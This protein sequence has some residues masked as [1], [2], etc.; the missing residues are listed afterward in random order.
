MQ[1]F[2]IIKGTLEFLMQL[3]VS[4]LRQNHGFVTILAVQSSGLG[5]DVLHVATAFTATRERSSALGQAAKADFKQLIH[6]LDVLDKIL[7]LK[8]ENFQGVL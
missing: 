3:D 4:G 1:Q 6:A 8:L 5:N 2:I 7:E